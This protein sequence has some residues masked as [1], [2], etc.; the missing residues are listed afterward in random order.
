MLQSYWCYFT[1]KFYLLCDKILFYYFYYVVYW[2]F[3]VPK[4]LCK[5]YKSDPYHM[6]TSILCNFWKW[7]WVLLEWDTKIIFVLDCWTNDNKGIRIHRVFW[8]HQRYLW[9]TNQNWVYL[10]KVPKL[11][12]K[13][14]WLKTCHLTAIWFLN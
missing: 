4:A 1:L 12:S 13:V 9:R 14:V 2:V 5:Y 6:C 7:V 10:T 11:M 3:Q 8:S